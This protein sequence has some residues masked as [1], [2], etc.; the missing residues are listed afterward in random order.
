MVP[1]SVNRNPQVNASDSRVV[2]CIEEK[3]GGF[4]LFEPEP[5]DPFYARVGT[6]NLA[7]LAAIS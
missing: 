3:S 2:G 7:A 1:A 5:F 6:D 4:L